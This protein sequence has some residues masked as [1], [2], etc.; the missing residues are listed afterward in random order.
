MSG[1]VLEVPG[2]EYLL[3]GCHSFGN[4]LT[5]NKVTSLNPVMKGWNNMVIRLLP[6]VQKK[7]QRAHLILTLGSNLPLGGV[8]QHV[9]AAGMEGITPQFVHMRGEGAGMALH[10]ALMY[11]IEPSS[12]QERDSSSCSSELL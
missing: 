11:C 4:D 10:V 7:C 5:G 3:K 12:E 6:D 1:V 9:H 8:V 2:R